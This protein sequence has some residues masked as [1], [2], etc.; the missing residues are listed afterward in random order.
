M[1]FHIQQAP[2][3]ASSVAA[4]MVWENRCVDFVGL[5]VTARPFVNHPQH[6]IGMHSISRL[7]SI[8]G[9]PELYQ[10]YGFLQSLN[11]KPISCNIAMLNSAPVIPRSFQQFLIFPEL[12]IRHAG[13]GKFLFET[14]NFCFCHSIHTP[15]FSQIK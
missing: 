5:L 10:L 14:L 1:H 13:L 9:D 4:N 12:I 15:L 8:P 2:R 7:T 3:I 6:I 11:R